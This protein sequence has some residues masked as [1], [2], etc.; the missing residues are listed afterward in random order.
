[1]IPEEEIVSDIPELVGADPELA[2]DGPLVL[3]CF[4]FCLCVLPALLLIISWLSK[5]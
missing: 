4:I 2:K 5:L 3:G 1:M